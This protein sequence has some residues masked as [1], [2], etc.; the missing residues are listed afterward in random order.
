MSQRVDNCNY[1]V[2]QY[3]RIRDGVKGHLNICLLENGWWMAF[4][5]IGTNAE[6]YIDQLMQ[7]IRNELFNL[8]VTERNIRG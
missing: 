5:D 1:Y 6:E 4:D 7:F 8:Q 2:I 3:T